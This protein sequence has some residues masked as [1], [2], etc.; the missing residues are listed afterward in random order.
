M[1][2][3]R[4][5]LSIGDEKRKKL[6]RFFIDEKL[7]KQQR[8]NLGIGNRQPDYLVVVTGLTTGLVSIL[9]TPDIDD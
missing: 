2:G 1:E 8:K 7:Q 6:A 3:R 9:Y 5:F 4:L